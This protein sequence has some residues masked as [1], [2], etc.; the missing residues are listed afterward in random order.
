MYR[1]GLNTRRKDFLHEHLPEPASTAR[2][3]LAT[4]TELLIPNT[5]I[6]V[7]RP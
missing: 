1:P 6:T 4:P 7:V 5:G 3:S 2:T